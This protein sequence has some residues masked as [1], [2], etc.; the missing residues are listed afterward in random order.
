MRNKKIVLFALIGLTLTFITGIAFYST[1]AELMP[2]DYVIYAGI[3]SIV[4]FSIIAIFK[5]LRDEKKGLVTE[6]ELSRK[7]KQKAAANSF[8]ASIYL[9]TMILLFTMDSNIDNEILLGIGIVGM[10]LIFIG[11]WLYH[12]NKGIESENPN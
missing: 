5:Q 6:D 11:F 2:V 10:G 12:N 1:M 4:L 8:T 3:G 7:I 9:W